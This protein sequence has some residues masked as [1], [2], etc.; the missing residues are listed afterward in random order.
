MNKKDYVK[1][2]KVIKEGTE[3]IALIYALMDIFEEDNPRFNRDTFLKACGLKQEEN[4]VEAVLT[5]EP[6]VGRITFTRIDK[7]DGNFR[8]VQLGRFFIKNGDVYGS[9]GLGSKEK[10]GFICF[11]EN[12]VKFEIEK[13]R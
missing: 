10:T 1:I 6:Q 3:P 8:S 7:N 11:V 9:Y 4:A 12:L 13:V 2:A 5:E